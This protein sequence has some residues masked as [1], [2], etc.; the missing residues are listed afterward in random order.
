MATSTKNVKVCVGFSP[1][2]EDLM[3]LIR[4]V[5]QKVKRSISAARPQKKVVS[6]YGIE[7]TKDAIGKIPAGLDV[8]F[9]LQYH[10]SSDSLNVRN[11]ELWRLPDTSKHVQSQQLLGPFEHPIERRYFKD[12]ELIYKY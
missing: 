7:V 5:S 11:D 1:I 9:R 2:E 4:T 10:Q 3:E 6:A 12:L 8:Q